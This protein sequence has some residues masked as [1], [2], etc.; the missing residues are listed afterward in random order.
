MVQNPIAEGVEAPDFTA[1]LY[2]RS[3]LTTIH[4]IGHTAKVAPLAIDEN[5]SPTGSR[6]IPTEINKPTINPPSDACHAGRRRI[7]SSARTVTI[8]NVA[9]TNDGNNPP[10]TGASNCGNIDVPLVS[11]SYI[12]IF[13]PRHTG[14]MRFAVR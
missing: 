9:T 10:G 13:E 6:Q 2:S 3:A 11:R 4:M 12:P 8:G 1:T 14:R 7:P 5:A